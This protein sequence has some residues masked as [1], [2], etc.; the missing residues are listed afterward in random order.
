MEAGM[1]SPNPDIF[2]SV[3]NVYL[4]IIISALDKMG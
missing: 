3:S 4:Y 2:G 1:S